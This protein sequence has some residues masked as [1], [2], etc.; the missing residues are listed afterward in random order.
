MQVS[1]LF[2]PLTRVA[3]P[4]QIFRKVA[5]SCYR[6]SLRLTGGVV[7]FAPA[8]VLLGTLHGPKITSG[9]ELRAWHEAELYSLGDLYDDGGLILVPTLVQKSRLPA[10]QFLL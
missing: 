9:P 4:D 5:Y 2:H 3:S 7:P 8:L 6:R 10:G 1:H